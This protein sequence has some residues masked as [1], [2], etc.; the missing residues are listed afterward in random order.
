MHMACG[1]FWRR[2]A[3]QGYLQ[4]QKH[5][6]EVVSPEPVFSFCML[7][8]M[9]EHFSISPCSF[10]LPALT[11]HRHSYKEYPRF[12]KLYCCFILWS[13]KEPFMISI[14]SCLQW[15]FSSRPPLTSTGTHITHCE[16]LP[17]MPQPSDSGAHMTGSWVGLLSMLPPTS[18]LFHNHHLHIAAWDTLT[19]LTTK[20]N[21]TVS[22][23]R[24]LQNR[25]LW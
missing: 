10:S 18:L 1:V 15:S 8:G 24:F 21:I 2:G 13:D 6:T 11:C 4:L 14:T 3:L 19:L 16:T 17:S 5:W 23:P 12:L 25:T 20:P 22:L 7:K 9:T